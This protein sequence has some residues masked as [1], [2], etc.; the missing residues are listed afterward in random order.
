M[1]L[2]GF[3]FHLHFSIENLFYS[4]SF[5][6]NQFHAGTWHW[7]VTMHFR[8]EYKKRM[9]FNQ[10]W[11]S[12]RSFN[13]P[14]R[15][16]SIKHVHSNLK[17]FKVRKRIRKR[18]VN[19]HQKWL[20]HFFRVGYFFFFFILLHKRIF[21]RDALSFNFHCKPQ[22]LLDSIW[23]GEQKKDLKRNGTFRYTRK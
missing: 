1:N 17:I 2:S 15:L 13:L 6:S 8:E 22:D 5:N 21:L 18:K 10:P 20:N 9:K 11:T 19:N 23:N 3:F 14:S 7:T 12:L 4:L 16:K